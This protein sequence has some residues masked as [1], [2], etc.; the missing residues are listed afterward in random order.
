MLLR[1]IK[2]IAIINSRKGVNLLKLRFLNKILILASK[3]NIK[4]ESP[5]IGVKL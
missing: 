2:Q 1:A 4:S 3:T 5:V